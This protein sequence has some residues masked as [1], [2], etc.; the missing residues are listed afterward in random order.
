MS[1]LADIR[2]VT[3]RSITRCRTVDGDVTAAE[4]DHSRG[5]QGLVQMA[6]R[7]PW[8]GERASG[9]GTGELEFEANFGIVLV[10]D[11]VSSKRIKAVNAQPAEEVKPV[12]VSV[13]R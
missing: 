9:A 6:S 8:G 13:R 3:P 1:R 2:T 5:P 7:A 4:I 10:M 11:A 12:Q